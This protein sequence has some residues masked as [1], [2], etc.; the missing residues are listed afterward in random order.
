M[1][2]GFRGEDPAW[3]MELEQSRSDTSAAGWSRGEYWPLPLSAQ[4]A[5]VPSV[6]CGPFG[7]AGERGTLLPFPFSVLSSLL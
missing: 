2:P 4:G 3:Q 5:Q 1:L 6:A 7:W